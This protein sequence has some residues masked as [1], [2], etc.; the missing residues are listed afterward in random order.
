MA[1]LLDINEA[2]DVVDAYGADDYLWPRSHRDAMMDLLKVDPEFVDYV[3]GTRKLDEML[4]NWDEQGD[5]DGVDVGED[6]WDDLDDMDSPQQSEPSDG[7]PSGGAPAPSDKVIEFDPSCTSDMDAMFSNAIAKMLEDTGD[8]EFRVFT[9]DYDRI[10][11]IEGVS[12]SVS[13]T[14]LD[15]SVAKSTGVLQKDMRRIIAARSQVKRVPG[16]RSGR[17]HAPNLHRILSG[18][19]RVF[20]RREE[21]QSLDTAISLVVD[22]S[23]S[24]RGSQIRLASESAYALGSVLNRIGIQFECLGFT[25]DDGVPTTDHK[26]YMEEVHRAEAVAPIARYTPIIMPKFKLFEERWTLPVQRRFARVFNG[27]KGYGDVGINMGM[28]PEGCAMEFAARRLLSRKEA[29]KIMIVMTDGEP[30]GHSVN[31]AYGRSLYARQSKDMVKAIEA[32][33]IDLVGVG[34]KHAGPTGYYSNAVVI[35]NVDQLPVELMRILK[36][37]VI[38]K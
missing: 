7:P 8:S 26:R 3:E 6:D 15:Q 5:T 14:E 35:D 31:Y 36:Q 18:D 17:L 34:I 19:D 25:S 10:V 22:C 20:T 9:R 12:D 27:A 23:G 38:G 4:E 37:F 32:A 11:E 21:A 16:K 2:M 28:T 29:R 24:M 33:G 30:A 1:L 13:L